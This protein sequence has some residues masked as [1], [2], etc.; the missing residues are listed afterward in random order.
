[1]KNYGSSILVVDDNAQLRDLLAEILTECGHSVRTAGDGHAALAEIHES[2]PDILL[3]DLNMP[4]MS[5]FELISL[6]RFRSSKI[7]IVAMSAD[8]SVEDQ[9]G[10]FDVDAFYSKGCG[11]VA[12]LLQIIGS[13]SAIRQVA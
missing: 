11:S 3:T 5:G 1:M 4:R 10:N 12:P 6:V 9:Q 2:E 13:M 7:A 8:V